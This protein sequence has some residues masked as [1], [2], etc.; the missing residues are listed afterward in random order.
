MQETV[1]E[2]IALYAQ[3]M[4]AGGRT[5]TQTHGPTA[6]NHPRNDA[7]RTT[8]TNIHDRLGQISHSL[9]RDHSRDHQRRSQTDRVPSDPQ[10]R[11]RNVPERG[12]RLE[13][14]DEASSSR[15]RDRRRDKHPEVRDGRTETYNPRHEINEGRRGYCILP[16]PTKRREIH[17]LFCRSIHYTA[18]SMS[19]PR[20]GIVCKPIKKL[21]ARSPFAHRCKPAACSHGRRAAK[22][23]TCS[24]PAPA[25]TGSRPSQIGQAGRP[26]FA[27]GR[28]YGHCRSSAPS[29]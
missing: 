29:A 4:S 3:T 28:P 19:H 14:D 16:V 15:S 12:E 27:A 1:N 24:K 5:Q 22:A 17:C 9:S 13:R 18:R 11:E 20:A 8:R 7:Q 6:P 23:P 2:A 26:P 10:H 25:S 21:P